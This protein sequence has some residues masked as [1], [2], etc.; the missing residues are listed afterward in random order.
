MKKKAAKD[1]GEREADY[2]KMKTKLEKLQ[3]L[4][5]DSLKQQD[6][7]VDTGSENLQKDSNEV[8]DKKSSS[9]FC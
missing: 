7:I 2:K 9:K 6:R 3:K 5:F 8:E 4:R 1:I